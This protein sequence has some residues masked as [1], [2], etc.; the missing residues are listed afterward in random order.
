MFV[1]LCSSIRTKY[2]YH[3]HAIKIRSRLGAQ[4][5]ICSEKTDGLEPQANQGDCNIMV[6]LGLIFPVKFNKPRS[7]P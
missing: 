1:A 7:S 6:P 5:E 2:Y 4:K 3:L